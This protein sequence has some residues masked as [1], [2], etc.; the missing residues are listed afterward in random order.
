M[1]YSSFTARATT[2]HEREAADR[3]VV[4]AVA[5]VLTLISVSL[6][7][8]A[9]LHLTG[10]VRGRAKPFDSG[11]AGIAE[12]IIGAVLAGGSI[13]IYRNARRART[14][15]LTVTVFAIVGFIVGLTVTTRAGRWPDIAYHL[16]IL[17]L[18]VG[19]LLILL[20]ATGP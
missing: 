3:H 20:R 19:S 7:V 16:T 1:S 11:D 15:G 6:A 2:D 9:I 13:A 4:R 12:A 8:A 17:P 10:Q 5:A 14:I 18:L